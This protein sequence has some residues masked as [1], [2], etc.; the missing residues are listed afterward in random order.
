MTEQHF[1]N[2]DEKLPEEYILPLEVFAKA[3]EINQ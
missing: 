2:D 3:W 1:N